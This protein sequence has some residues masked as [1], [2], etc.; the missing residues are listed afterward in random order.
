MA[1]ASREHVGKRRRKARR[2]RHR[3]RASRMKRFLLSAWM[4]TRTILR[5][6]FYLLTATAAASLALLFWLLGI[7]VPSG[8]PIHFP[9]SSPGRLTR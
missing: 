1:E 3:S 7:V 9:S 8:N 2:R 6:P 5:S 4:E